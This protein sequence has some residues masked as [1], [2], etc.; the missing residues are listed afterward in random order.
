MIKYL[1]FKWWYYLLF[2]IVVKAIFFFSFQYLKSPDSFSQG[3]FFIVTGD[4]IDYFQP[5]D[6][7][8]K[9]G[10]HR[11]DDG[12]FSLRMPGY[13]PI[14]LIYRLLFNLQWA[15]NLTLFTQIVLS[16][17][18]CYLLALIAQRMFKSF[19]VFL[20]VFVGYTFSTYVSIW[21]TYILSESF[22]TSFLIVSIYFL[23][24]ALIKRQL[25]Y[26]L[27]CGFFVTWSIFLRPFIFPVII[28]YAL[29]IF[30]ENYSSSN[31]KN[32]I[33]QLAIF[34][35]PFFIVES[36][37]V[38]RNYSNTNQLLLTQSRL[39]YND[40]DEVLSERL[41]IKWFVG[42]F[43]SSFGGDHTYWNP[44]GASYWF[45]NETNNT[46]QDLFPNEIFNDSLT[47][48]KLL[49]VRQLCMQLVSET[50]S[51]S[52]KNELEAKAKNTLREF[53]DSY[54]SNHP[55]H[56]HIVSRFIHLKKYILHSGVYNLPFPSFD[57]QSVFQKL[58]KG[59]YAVIYLI[60]IIIGGLS[61][62]L[63]IRKLSS[64]ILLFIFLFI[65]WYLVFLFP[66]FKVHEFRFNTLA[67]PFFLVC[68][69]VTI[70][71]AYEYF[72]KRSISIN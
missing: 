24:E 7:L 45:F 22:S 56:Y 8:V 10:E 33:V 62:L 64:N 13:T 14:L 69:A 67:Y 49:M 72:R 66:L 1:K 9:Y 17:I 39:S 37:W 4:A 53:S 23:Q 51:D 70:V 11:T 60:V 27:W 18:S 54:S 57:N 58:F 46:Y 21:D 3:V 55:F 26:F 68:L 6:N 59:F 32:K 42:A 19:K 35:I 65:P 71:K 20:L 61:S 38:L 25:K 15:L 50:M 31:M 63:L 48:E 34:S 29:I 5:V 40:D 36:S 52:K 44:G 12:Q 47:P 16:G 2:A 28:I 30:F 41:P 43:C